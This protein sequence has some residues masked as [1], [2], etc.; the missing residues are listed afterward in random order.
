MIDLPCSSSIGSI[1]R[2]FTTYSPTVRSD[3][4]LCRKKVPRECPETEAIL[5][6]CTR[7]AHGHAFNTCHNNT[8]TKQSLHGALRSAPLCRTS[9][10]AN[11]Q[12]T[13][14][15]AFGNIHNTPLSWSGHTVTTLL[16]AR[17]PRRCS[18]CPRPLSRRRVAPRPRLTAYGAMSPCLGSVV[19]IPAVG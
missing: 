2:R 9:R 11:L 18:R 1:I 15:N 10:I 7:R 4:G 17:G 14:S 19:R 6:T 13:T 5:A 3:E 8:W 12:S 16:G